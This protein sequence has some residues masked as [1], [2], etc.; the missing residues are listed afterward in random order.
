MNPQVV[1]PEAGISAQPAGRPFFPLLLLLFIGSGCSALIYEIVWYQLLQLV[2]GSTAVSLGVL[3]ATFMG[4]LCLG[5]LAVPRL[6]SGA[7]ASFA[8]LRAGGVG[9]RRV[10]FGGAVR[11]ALVGSVVRGGGGAWVAGHAAAG[12]AVCRGFTCCRLR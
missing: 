4:G 1:Q 6:I 11:N 5:S 10:R 3:L 12:G 9:H 2:I 7:R 8:D